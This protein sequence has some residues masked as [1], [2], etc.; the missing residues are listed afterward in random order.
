[1]PFF[2]EIKVG[3]RMEL[4]SFH[5]SAESIIAF[6]REFDPQPFHL[7]EE[8]GR[9]SL[10]GGLAA[11]GWH[12]AAVWMKLMV[13]SRLAENAERV[14][15]GEAPIMVGPSPGFRD[16]KWIKPVMA[17]DTIAYASEV[18]GLRESASRPGWGLVEIVNTGTNQKGETVYSFVGTV[19]FPKSPA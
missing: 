16:L 2:N 18:S 19:F 8:E 14:A 15:R 1:M 4:G 12:T 9:K 17:G 7:S 10:F 5:F 11:S 3:D 13:A 6:A